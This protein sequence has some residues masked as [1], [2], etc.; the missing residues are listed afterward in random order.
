MVGGLVGRASGEGNGGTCGGE[1]IDEA[2]PDP[3]GRSGDHDDL[4]VERE[5]WKMLGVHPPD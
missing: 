5:R 2:T 3:A 4:S 1:R